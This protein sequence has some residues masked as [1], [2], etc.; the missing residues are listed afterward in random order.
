MRLPEFK[1]EM[2]LD[3]FGFDT[4]TETEQLAGQSGCLAVRL[5]AGAASRMLI[6]VLMLYVD[7]TKSTQSHLCLA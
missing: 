6:M 1:V 4:Q 3:Y 7:W 2:G 5:R